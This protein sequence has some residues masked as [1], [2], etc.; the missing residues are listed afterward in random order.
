METLCKRCHLAV[1]DGH[2]YC[3]QCGM[4]QLMYDAPEGTPA[5]EVPEGREQPVLD[6]GSVEWKAALRSALMLAIPSGILCSLLSPLGGIPGLLL[7]GATGAWAV[8][9]YVRRR[10]SSWLT[11]GAGARIGMVTGILGGWSAAFISGATLFAMRYVLHQ[12]HV[13]D[14]FWMN[15]VNQQMA[16]Q[17]TAMGVDAQTI[18]LAR[19]WMLSPEG[20]AGWVLSALVFLAA[21]ML[22]CGAAGGAVGARLLARTRRPEV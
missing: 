8:V 9:H 1:E 16:Q 4:P 6:A 12:G 3:P 13:F 22:V 14:D 20:R 17:W 15:L 7:M 21:G 19:S 11:L 5:S 2:S 10:R 18:T